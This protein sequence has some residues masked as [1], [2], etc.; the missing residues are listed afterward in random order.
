MR[1]LGVILHE[2][3]DCSHFLE[4]GLLPRRERGNTGNMK[5]AKIFGPDRDS[6]PDQAPGYRP[7][8]LPLTITRPTT[9]VH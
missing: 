9:D 5:L 8:A 1:F 3:H 4:L 7:S 6:D 2:K